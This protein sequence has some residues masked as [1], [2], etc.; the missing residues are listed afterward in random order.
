MC[1]CLCVLCVSV[2]VDKLTIWLVLY[3]W[4]VLR[5]LFVLDVYI[6]ERDGGMVTG[7]MGGVFLSPFNW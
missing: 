7:G 6:V 2:C 1:V 4:S 5:P 3:S